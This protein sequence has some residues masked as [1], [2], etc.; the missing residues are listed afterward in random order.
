MS[1]ASPRWWMLAVTA[2]LLGVLTACELRA[3]TPFLD[4]RMLARNR[5]LTTTY[6]RFGITML[7]TYG[8]IYGWTPWLEHSAGLSAA[9]TGLVMMSS[10]AV[11]A[12]VS[13][14]AARHSRVWPLLVPRHSRRARPACCCSPGA[15]RCGCCG[16]SAS[17]SAR[18]TGSA[19][20]AVTLSDRKLA[21]ARP[22]AR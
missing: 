2:V 14:L 6:V 16:R 5:A 8:F 20:L 1:L 9:S 19:L 10:F 12:V 18:R 13:A 11:A 17:F 4:V 7:I 21:T 3:R 22:H 15:H